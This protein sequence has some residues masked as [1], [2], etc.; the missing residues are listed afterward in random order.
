MSASRSRSASAFAR[1]TQSRQALTPCGHSLHADAVTAQDVE[2]LIE[3]RRKVVK[4]KAVN[5]DLGAL[6][7]TYTRAVKHGMLKANPIH[8]VEKLAM[9][10]RPI[11]PLTTAED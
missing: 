5:N 8:G 2:L 9:I 10:Q 6:K 4:A 1:S 3:A 11:H 7:A